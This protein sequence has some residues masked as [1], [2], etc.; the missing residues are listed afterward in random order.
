MSEE[1]KVH[2]SN[3]KIIERKLLEKGCKFLEETK[4]IDTYYKQPKGVVLKIVEKN[5]GDFLNFFQAANG[6]F[7]VV[8]D[9]SINN[10]KEL[11]KELTS[12]YGVK[13]VLK[14][15]RKFFQFK[16]YKI[17]FNLIENVGEFLILVG[18]NPSKSFI[19]NELEIKNPKYISV[20]FDEVE[21][22][23]I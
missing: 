9:E 10:A 23:N 19:E 11:K 4:F 22:N 20:S 3:Y 12:Q 15:K 5:K 14:G 21:S 17:I 8:K 6:K 7:E 1:L 16:E 2:I 13:R 18:E